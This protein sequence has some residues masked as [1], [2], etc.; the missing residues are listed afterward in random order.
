V[1]SMAQTV[2]AALTF[3]PGQFCTFKTRGR[4]SRL[5]SERVCWPTLEYVC[6]CMC[7]T[8]PHF[9]FGPTVSGFSCTF[10]LYRLNLLAGLTIQSGRNISPELDAIVVVSH[11]VVSIAVVV[12]LGKG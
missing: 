12:D 10:L 4:G 1:Q 8:Q 2:P 5:N 7:V 6:V 9:Q 11:A 3:I